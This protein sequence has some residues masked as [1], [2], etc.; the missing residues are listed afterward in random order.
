MRQP[1]ERV[2]RYYYYERRRPRKV[3]IPITYLKELDKDFKKCGEECSGSNYCRKIM[4]TMNCG[5]GN[6]SL[7]YHLTV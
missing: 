3:P 6:F 2:V 7:L 1:Y 4:T 5:N